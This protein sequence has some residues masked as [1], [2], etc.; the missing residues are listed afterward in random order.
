M[1]TFDYVIAGGGT[2]ACILARRLGEAGHSVCMIEA[3]RADNTIWTRIPAGFTRLLRN[4]AFSWQ[5]RYEGSA[6]TNGRATPLVQGRTLGGS[7][8]VNGAVFSRGQAFDYDHWAELGNAG[9]SY[10]DILPYFRKLETF[11]G[12]ANDKVRGR[13]GPIRVAE[14]A[15]RDPVCETFLDAAGELGI[16]RTADYNGVQQDG[17]G[18]CQS[19]IHSGRRWSTAHGYLHPSK[20]QFGTRVITESLVTQVLTDGKRATGL[21]YR[22]VAGGPTQQVAAR[23]EVLICAGAIHSPKLLQLSGIGPA[24]LLQEHGVPVVHALSG[25][26]ENLRDHYCPRIVTRARPGVPSINGKVR[27]LPLLREILAWA[28][29]RPSILSISPILLYGFWKSQPQLP[30]PDFVLSFMPVSYAQGRIGELDVEP[31][32]TCGAW[33]LRPKS[34]GFVRIASRDDNIAPVIQPNFLSH[35]ED[36]RVAVEALKW[37]RAVMSSARMQPLVQTELLPGDGVRNDE[38][39]LNYA[40]AYGTT[41]FHPVGT[42]RMGAA[43]DPLAVVDAQLRV[44]GMESLRVIDASIMP[45][46]PSGNTCAATMM[47]AEKAA[48]ML[49]EKHA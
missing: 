39:M 26:G 12:T 1:E 24:A 32:L 34:Q 43:N 4:P 25:V 28:T 8:A 10:A 36:Q 16:P 42:C 13:S 35:S 11:I 9:W 37:A 45:T 47:I 38:D 48:D 2:A 22:P 5:L 27:G 21:A 41:G 17:I 44:H 46:I 33:Q 23:R 20:R 29:N 19:S 3:G 15:W 49:C 18:Y 31:G 40:R 30:S 6:G 14:T 7:S